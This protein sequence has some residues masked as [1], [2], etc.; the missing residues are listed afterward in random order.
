MARAGTMALALGIAL[1]VGAA[2]WLLWSGPEGD[3]G[4]VDDDAARSA[5]AVDEGPV[6]AAHGGGKP[7]A[8]SPEVEGEFD[9]LGKVVD[10]DDR[11]VAG[12]PVT[13]RR[14][15]DPAG[16]E[17]VEWTVAQRADRALDFEPPE[18]PS[19][20][21]PADATGT[22]GPDG[23]FTLR[24]R[25]RGTYAVRAEPAAPL[26][27]TQ[28]EW[29]LE[30]V[31][32]KDPV[33]LQVLAGSALRGRVVDALGRGVEAFVRA[34]Q[35][36]GAWWQGDWTPTAAGTG[37]FAL[38]AVPA[39]TLD[40]A[41]FVPGRW[42]LE[43]W[44]FETPTT[45]E[46]V[47]RVGA[48]ARLASGTVKD[49]AGVPVAGARVTLR[50]EATLADGARSLPLAARL[51]AVSDEAGAFAIES[52]VT[53]RVLSLRVD[54]T[55]FLD[56]VE[57]PSRAPW[58]GLALEPTREAVFPVVLW[59]GGTLE[60]RVLERRSGKPLP[61]AVVEVH[62]SAVDAHIPQTPLR[63][64]RSDASGRF[65]V[66]GL[67]VGLGLLSVKHPTHF[68][69]PLET[70]RERKKVTEDMDQSVVPPPPPE[71]TVFIAQDGQRV[72]RDLELVPGVP[73]K[74]RV[75][76]GQ[77]APVS[78]A[79]VLTTGLGIGDA[80]W[81]WNVSEEGETQVLATSGPDGRFTV[82]GLPPRKEW[83]LHARKAPLCGERSRP[84]PLVEGADAVEIVLRLVGTATIAGWVVDEHAQPVADAHVSAWGDEEQGGIAYAAADGE[85]RDS[86]PTDA[87]GAFRIERLSPGDVHLW[88]GAKA[89]NG[90]TQVKGL[91]PDEV[92]T[93][94]EVRLAHRAG[95]S[96]RGVVVYENGAP[97]RGRRIMIS[98]IDGRWNSNLTTDERDGTFETSCDGPRVR[99]SAGDWQLRITLTEVD[100]PARDV[101][102][103][104]KEPAKRLLEGLV[105][106]AQGRPVP[107]CRVQVDHGPR[108][109]DSSSDD[110]ETV[111]NGWFRRDV[112][113]KPPF[114]VRVTRPQDGTGRALNLRAEPLTLTE[115]P[116]GAVTITLEPGAA[117]AGQV[118]D[119][120]GRGIAEVPVTLA[121]LGTLTDA[122]GSFVFEGLGSGP[123]SLQVHPPSPWMRPAARQV[124]AGGGPE[125]V[126]L[127]AGLPIAGLVRGEKGHDLAGRGSVEAEWG[128][129]T[130]WEG[131][132]TS[133][134]IER[135][136]A[137]RLEGLPPGATVTLTVWVWDRDELTY[138]NRPRKVAAGTENLVIDLAAGVEVSG[139]VSDG[140][141]RAF[142]NGNV[143]VSFTQ[144]EEE[145]QTY[146]SI[147]S[148]GTFRLLGV[149]PGRVTVDLYR[150]DGG[151]KP[152]PLAV[153]APASG[154]KLVVPADLPLKG[155]LVG[156][157]D[158][159]ATFRVWAWPVAEKEGEADGDSLRNVPVAADGSFVLGAAGATG[160]WMLAANAP[161]DDRYALVGPVAAGS[162]NVVLR[163]VPGVSIEG[164][165]TTAAGP[166][167]PRPLFASLAG[168][169]WSLRVKADA[170][171]RFALR[172]LPAG[173]YTVYAF[174]WA[175]GYD[176]A[177]LE[178][179]E[180][181]RRDLR[182]V[183]PVE[184][185]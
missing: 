112:P 33:E 8:S 147:D 95:V 46:V 124:S 162:E 146:A 69:V 11:A 157:G 154:L 84:F 43:G 145:Q 51:L 82:P 36:R 78:G 66:E 14:T 118:V 104:W 163:L 184:T 26:V 98:S 48:G 30:R 61:G 57:E 111:V 73:L 123:A 52:G 80:A 10:E 87:S 115:A 79:E 32:P 130:G 81:A 102:V 138:A 150:R 135:D 103:V 91:A 44:R 171:G 92:R 143:V 77:G 75:V 74:G 23:T 41:V 151:A 76:D 178:D 180:A 176:T 133:A 49:G 25:R 97:A 71:A 134:Q 40:F 119:G 31:P 56:F 132:E 68:F 169:H 136:G 140:A 113:D 88:A 21:T 105:V 53:G 99:I 174:T 161:D 101:R 35:V 100:V 167:L 109:G 155:R 19:A 156:A 94:V 5:G 59:R 38:A 22:S 120:S 16:E 129:G 142:R 55:G 54:A 117:L 15:A 182:L 67:A 45:E 62:A 3:G 126:V 175:D 170:E 108:D 13:A 181:G 183:L 1:A 47:L 166:P 34:K 152:A 39:G 2:G 85:D 65:V 164:T 106:D 127:K 128:P 6:L 110:G 58:T 131:G 114:T 141:G 116:T 173:R 122:S 121:G 90:S 29:I 159:A 160:R 83:T 165:I 63:T 4:T 93:G 89:G 158:A 153:T 17:S 139:T 125:V 168:N 144:D 42:N 64:A 37:Q 148:N 50:V 12:V 60:G 86:A 96:L 18:A 20:R 70:L 149:P 9:I 185:K 107:L 72:T 137:F 28:D 24:V 179:V 177:T 27:G 7:L 172:G